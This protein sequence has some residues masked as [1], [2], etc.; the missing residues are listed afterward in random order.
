VSNCIGIDASYVFDDWPNGAKMIESDSPTINGFGTNGVVKNAT[1]FERD[2]K[3]FIVFATS[4][5]DGDGKPDCSGDLGGYIGLAI[6][7][8]E[9]A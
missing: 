8:L 9:L 6:H 1:Y 4:D 2:G 7:E 5:H 3:P